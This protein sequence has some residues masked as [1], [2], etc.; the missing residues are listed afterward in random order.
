VCTVA[1]AHW[2]AARTL[3]DYALT[4]CTVGPG[5]D[6]ADFTILADDAATAARLLAMWPELSSLV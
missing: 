6:F 1:A 2:Q 3:G 5:F 4:G